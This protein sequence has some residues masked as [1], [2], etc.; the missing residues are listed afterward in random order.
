MKH[1]ITYAIV[2]LITT[3][4]LQG[5]ARR[6]HPQPFQVNGC[7]TNLG[8][9]IKSTLAGN[10]KCAGTAMESIQS[11]GPS[12]FKIQFKNYDRG[13][14]LKL[15]ALFKSVEEGGVITPDVREEIDGILDAQKP[16]PVAAPR[17]RKVVVPEPVV[18]VVEEA[19]VAS[20]PLSVEEQ[21]FQEKRA[22]ACFTS[23]TGT[24]SII[25]ESEGTGKP[26]EEAVFC[27]KKVLKSLENPDLPL[28]QA[29]KIKEFSGKYHQ[30]ETWQYRSQALGE[31]VRPVIEDVAQGKGVPASQERELLD[32]LY[33][34]KHGYIG[35]PG[36]KG[37]VYEAQKPF[38]R[39]R[40]EP[41]TEVVAQPQPRFQR[42]LSEPVT[43]TEKQSLADQLK[44]VKLRTMVKPAAQEV[45]ARGV[46]LSQLKA[47]KFKPVG[48]VERPSF[49]VNED[50][51]A[52]ALEAKRKEIMPKSGETD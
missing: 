3:S 5:H 44:G 39:T 11:A 1:I 31:I 2:G 43:A 36:H 49:R 52:K 12:N 42:T 32:A 8:Y 51:F 6:H 23:F 19:P 38:Q 35:T 21:W 17:P 50:A 40:S 14:R 48:A 7:A 20:V 13:S 27:A 33:T 18:A 24:L 10:K 22:E 34:L 25:S 15:V 37:P 28:S 45:P 26:T 41:L 47:F 29:S 16:V 4:A 9:A 30:F 46:T